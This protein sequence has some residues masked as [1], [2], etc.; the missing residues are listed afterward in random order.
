M[1]VVRTCYF[2]D[3]FLGDTEIKCD[4][5]F[6]FERK[7]AAV[8]DEVECPKCKRKGTICAKVILWVRHK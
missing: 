4:C 5:G 6:E 1:K 8:D 3:G 2:D 7:E